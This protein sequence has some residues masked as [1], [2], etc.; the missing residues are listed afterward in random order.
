[1]HH[2]NA[3]AVHLNL[4]KCFYLGVYNLRHNSIPRH[5]LLE[6]LHFSSVDTN[7]I[8]S[9]KANCQTDMISIIIQ[10]KTTENVTFGIPYYQLH[11]RIHMEPLPHRHPQ[12]NLLDSF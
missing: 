11:V 7:K 10:S 5:S 3:H 8:T 1:M 2:T 12:H 6:K 9:M 4:S